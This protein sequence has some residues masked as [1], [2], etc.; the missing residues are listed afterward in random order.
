MSTPQTPL[1]I[2]GYVAIVIIAMLPIITNTYDLILFTVD[3]SAFT[4]NHT[5]LSWDKQ[6]A[7]D[8]SKYLWCFVC[9]YCYLASIVVVYF[10][11]NTK[12]K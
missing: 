3:K 2:T 6:V 1:R 12:Q 4:P 10:S 7:T 5:S 8:F 11:T 9:L